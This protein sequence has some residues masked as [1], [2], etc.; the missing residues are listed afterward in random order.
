MKNDLIYTFNTRFLDENNYIEH[1]DL[2]DAYSVESPLSEENIEEFAKENEINLED[3]EI[4][5]YIVVNEK[6]GP[7]KIND[8]VV[9]AYQMDP[10][11]YVFRE[12]K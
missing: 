10:I 9:T 11:C 6:N 1:E 12:V 7:L 5:I 8:I 2:I 3:E 4:S